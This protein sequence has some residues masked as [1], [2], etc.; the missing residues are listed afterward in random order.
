MIVINNQAKLM[1]ELG[2]KDIKI[3]VLQDEISELK[4]KI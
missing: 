4:E 1:T 2:Q 3:K